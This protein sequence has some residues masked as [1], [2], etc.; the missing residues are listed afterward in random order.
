M[1]KSDDQADAVGVDTLAPATLQRMIEDCAKFQICNAALL[2]KAQHDRVGNTD[3]AAGHDFWLTRNGD[4]AG[5]WD[6]DWP[7]PYATQL[8][9]ACESFGEVNLYLG[10]DGLIYS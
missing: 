4:G 2:R 3:E 5:F 8:S 10:D 9:E 6:G 1:A 7:E